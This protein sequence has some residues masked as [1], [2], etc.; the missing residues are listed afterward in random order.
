MILKLQMQ[1]DRCRK[2]VKEMRPEDIIHGV[3]EDYLVLRDRWV[4][5]HC[6]RIMT[7]DERGKG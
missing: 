1:C 4:C 5:D 6:V 3:F 2:A 7:E